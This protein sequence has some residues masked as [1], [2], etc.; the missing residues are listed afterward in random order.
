M[1][2]GK[3]SKIG[4]GI[5]IILVVLVSL[6]LFGASNYMLDYSLGYP[7]QERMTAEHWKNRIKG[8][9][10]WVSAPLREGYFRHDAI[11]QQSTCALS[12]FAENFSCEYHAC[13]KRDECFC[14]H[15]HRGTWL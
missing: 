3:R 12:L 5:A 8:E 9:C 14:E 13:R 6:G 2:L 1:K 7:R 15:C 10:P 4:I 11:G